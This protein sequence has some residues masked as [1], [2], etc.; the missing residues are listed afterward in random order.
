MIR[1][2]CECGRQLQATENMIGQAASCPLCRRITVVPAS[3]VSR[4]PDFPPVWGNVKQERIQIGAWD[5]PDLDS[6]FTAAKVKLPPSILSLI[7]VKQ[8]VP[9]KK[10]AP[11]APAQL[12]E[13]YRLKDVPPHRFLHRH[14]AQYLSGPVAIKSGGGPFAMLDPAKPPA[15]F[16]RAFFRS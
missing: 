4:T 13:R 7:D 1:F 10:A 11:L 2:W 6:I 14:F 5:F 8:P 9:L 16:R 15:T 3:D 12:F